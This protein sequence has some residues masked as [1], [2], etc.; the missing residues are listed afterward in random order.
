MICASY[1]SNCYCLASRSL[2]TLNST[3]ATYAQ[4]AAGQNTT[5]ASLLEIEN[6][7]PTGDVAQAI[8]SGVFSQSTQIFVN[9]KSGLGGIGKLQIV[10]GKT[11]RVITNW[12]FDWTGIY[13][14]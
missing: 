13:K 4:T 1:E 2:T 12:G 5:V 8:I 6:E 14:K 9:N 3:Q 11:Q 10:K 7:Y